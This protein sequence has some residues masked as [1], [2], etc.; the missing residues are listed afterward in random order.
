MESVKHLQ[1]ALQVSNKNR[2]V[3]ETQKQADA[4]QKLQDWMQ[5]LSKIK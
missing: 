3:N 4:Q 2:D 1:N 5:E